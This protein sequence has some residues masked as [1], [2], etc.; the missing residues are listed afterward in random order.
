MKPETQQYVAKGVG[1]LGG[2]VTA[3]VAPGTG[4]TKDNIKSAYAAVDAMNLSFD[5]K[6][7]TMAALD[8]R[9]SRDDRIVTQTQN[10]AYDQALT[11]SNQIGTKFT[12]LN[13]LPPNVR[14]NLSPEHVASLTKLAESNA[15]PA[16]IP[17]NGDTMITLHQQAVLDPD[18]FAKTDL[19]VYRPNMTPGEYSELTQLQTK[20]IAKPN[21]P[22][23]VSHQR[24]WRQV[25]FYGRDIGIDMG[26]QKKDEKP[27]AFKARRQ[28]GQNLFNVMDNTLSAITDRKR[29][30]TDDEIKKAYDNAIM[31]KA[32][33]NNEAIP[34]FRMVG[35]PTNSVAI[36]Q[37]VHDDLRNR[38]RAAGLPYDDQSIARMYIKGVR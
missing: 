15:T 33:P 13:Q 23:V 27:E 12:S 22:D 38:R 31:T 26:V 18:K 28:D 34:R 35:A 8:R 7:A 25:E 10:D 6:K 19:R 3:G 1:M 36:P 32:G 5:E 2:T 11:M 4:P 14:Q 21:D 16:P 9:M 37:A 17:A 29:Q 24:I 30:P 20:Q